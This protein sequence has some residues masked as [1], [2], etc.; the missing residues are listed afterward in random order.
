MMVIAREVIPHTDAFLIPS[1]VNV[2]EGCDD[3]ETVLALIEAISASPERLE[4]LPKSDLKR[5]LGTFPPEVKDS[6]VAL[7]KLVDERDA[8]RLSVLEGVERSLATG[9]VGTGR[10]LFY[11]KAL[12][13][14]CH[15]VEGNGG[16]FGPDLTNIGEIRSQHDIL[17]AIVYPSASFAREY[18]TSTVITRDATYS[19]IV[20]EQESDHFVLETSPGA[21]VRVAISDIKSIDTRPLSMMPPGLHQ[22]LSVAELS[23]LMA[24]LRSLPDGLGHFRSSRE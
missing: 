4:L 23:D 21:K 2:F 22:Q 18:E 19:G 8:S 6:S 16:T 24:Y 9:D 13:S 5:I 12:C 15:A 11:G 3:R 7:M 20:K 17:E 1:L 10:Q 14:T